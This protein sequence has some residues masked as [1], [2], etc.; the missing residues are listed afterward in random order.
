MS[1]EKL[2][3]SGRGQDEPP[4]RHLPTRESVTDFGLPGVADHHAEEGRIEAA[5]D[6]MDAAKIESK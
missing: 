5:L 6:R 1:N 4:N 3:P 2:F